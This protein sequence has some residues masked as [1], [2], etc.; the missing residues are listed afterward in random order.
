MIA[1]PEGARLVSGGLS[2]LTYEKDGIAYRL[3]RPSDPLF[4]EAD[5]EKR[6]YE[7][8]SGTIFP[9]LLSFKENGDMESLYIAGAKQFLGPKASEDEMFLLGR[10]IKAFHSLNVPGPAASFD[11]L[12]RLREYQAISGSY[13]LDP[14]KV[15][16][17]FAIYKAYLEEGPLAPCHNDL[18]N[19]NVLLKDGRIWLIDLEFAGTNTPYFDLASALSE[20]GITDESLQK[21]LLKGYFGKDEIEEELKKTRDLFPFLDALWHYWALYRYKMTRNKVFLE[22]AEEK[23]RAFSS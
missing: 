13:L 2:N 16:K 5:Y 8:G 12:K 6:L 19:G 22:I 1:I 17:A 9:D 18:V 20:N 3:K 4:Y 7:S 11:G 15:E 14:E 23:A 10:T 21:A